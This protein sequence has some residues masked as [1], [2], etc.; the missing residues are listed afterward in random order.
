MSKLTDLRN[1]LLRLAPGP[2]A[3]VRRVE[4]LL[5]ESSIALR[6]GTSF[7]ESFQTRNQSSGFAQFCASPCIKAEKRATRFRSLHLLS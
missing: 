2:V 3:E 6:T 1:F 4:R 7:R 5:I